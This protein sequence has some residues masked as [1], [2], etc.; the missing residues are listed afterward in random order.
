LVDRPGPDQEAEDPSQLVSGQRVVGRAR[1]LVCGQGLD[2][3][4]ARCVLLFGPEAS[5]RL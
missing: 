3:D 2:G 1:V 4:P 5:S